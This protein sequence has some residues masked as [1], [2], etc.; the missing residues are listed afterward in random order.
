MH[1]NF[2]IVEM[3]YFYH[4]KKKKKNK[5]DEDPFIKKINFYFKKIK[6]NS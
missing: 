6:I 3:L 2:S 4:L 5:H 1:F